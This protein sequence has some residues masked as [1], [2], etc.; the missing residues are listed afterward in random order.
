MC[1]FGVDIIVLY[2]KRVIEGQG[3]SLLL[4][5]LFIMYE[6]LGLVFSGM[7]LNGVC[8]MCIGKCVLLR[9]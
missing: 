1:V 8:L 3:C 7:L 4:E 6:V 9:K 2:M 5:Y